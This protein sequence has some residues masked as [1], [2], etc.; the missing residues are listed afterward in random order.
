MES[1]PAIEEVFNLSNIGKTS[2]YILKINHGGGT[3][4][5]SRCNGHSVESKWVSFKRYKQSKAVQDHAQES[6]QGSK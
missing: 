2:I 6:Q 1:I 4:K 5:Y 3:V